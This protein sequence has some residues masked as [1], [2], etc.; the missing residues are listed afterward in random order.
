MLA[1]GHD[2]DLEIVQPAPSR[3]ISWGVKAGYSIVRKYREI[4][5][6]FI[7]DHGHCDVRLDLS[8]RPQEPSMPL[9]NLCALLLKGLIGA[10]LRRSSGIARISRTV[11]SASLSAS[12][13]IESMIRAF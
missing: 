8:L 11:S 7:C 3:L 10:P 9:V 13:I 2:L 1:V 4:G 6:A 5:N 12:A